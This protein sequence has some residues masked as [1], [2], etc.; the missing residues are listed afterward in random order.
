MLLSV[1]RCGV[2]CCVDVCNM[3]R[4]NCVGLRFAALCDLMSYCAALC[5]AVLPYIVLWF[6][7][8]CVVRCRI[9]LSCVVLYCV[10][11]HVW[12]CPVVLSID[13]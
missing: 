7:V 1:A 4:C 11:C 13:G 10:C 6:V 2:V 5:R 3:L 8:C 12:C 9:V